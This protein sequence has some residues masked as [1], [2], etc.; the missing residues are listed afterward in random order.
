MALCAVACHSPNALI[1]LCA[2]K[3]GIESCHCCAPPHSYANTHVSCA[4]AVDIILH[5]AHRALIYISQGQVVAP[6]P[7]AASPTPHVPAHVRQLPRQQP[8]TMPRSTCTW[9]PC[10]DGHGQSVENENN[11]VSIRLGRHHLLH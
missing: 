11:V 7:A 6:A 10:S 5:Q 1:G 9:S 4:G 8:G 3:T 2:T